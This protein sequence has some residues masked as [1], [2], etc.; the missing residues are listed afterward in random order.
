MHLLGCLW[1]KPSP[2]FGFRS[3]PQENVQP[4]KGRHEV[5]C[6]ETI[7]SRLVSYDFPF[8]GYF[9][10]H[11]LAPQKPR[12]RCE[13]RCSERFDHITDHRKESLCKFCHCSNL[14]HLMICWHWKTE[15]GKCLGPFTVKVHT[16]R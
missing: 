3:S 11:A 9:L 1:G 6:Q 16:K 15:S 10:Y 13:S 14:S 2:Y 7:F 5:W 8:H 12:R 4:G